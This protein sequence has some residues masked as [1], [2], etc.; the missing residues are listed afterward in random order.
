MPEKLQFIF[1]K[2]SF[3]VDNPNS[4]VADSCEMLRSRF[5]ENRYE[6]LFQLAF[7]DAFENES[8]SLV[9]LRILSQKFSEAIIDI[10]EIEILRDKAN[11][12]LAEDSRNAL[13]REVPFGPGTENI[14]EEWIESV[15]RNLNEIFSKELRA[16]KGSVQMFLTEKSQRLR[17]PE[18]I[19]FPSRRKS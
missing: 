19:F 9:F 14:S 8:P 1:T 5:V 4:D 3:I 17:V 7:D 15:V 11:I 6:A 12:Q 18:R 16:Y 13:L 2:D 10:P